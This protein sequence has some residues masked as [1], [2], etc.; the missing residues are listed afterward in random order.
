MS[1]EQNQPKFDLISP[2]CRKRRYNQR[3]AFLGKFTTFDI[4]LL[5][6]AIS[7]FSL[8]SRAMIR[9]YVILKKNHFTCQWWI[10]EIEWIREWIQDSYIIYLIDSDAAWKSELS[11]HDWVLTF[12]AKLCKLFE[13]KVIKP[14]LS[15]VLILK[16]G[17]I[18]LYFQRF[19]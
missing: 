8:S 2:R 5:I 11:S 17:I 13:A 6:N 1:W 12:P 3:R 14:M 9:K 18:L 16:W 4:Q 15:V 19:S 7:F 10:T